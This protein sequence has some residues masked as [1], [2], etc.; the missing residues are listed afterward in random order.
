MLFV[1][2]WTWLCQLVFVDRRRPMFSLA[3]SVSH[4]TETGQYDVSTVTDASKTVRDKII[5]CDV[6][7]GERMVAATVLRWPNVLKQCP[8]E[9]MQWPSILKKCSSTPQTW[10]EVKSKCPPNTI[11]DGKA[12]HAEFR[13]LQNISTLVSN[14]RE[15]S[16][17]LL[18]FYVLASPC[19][20]RCTSETNDW[21][22]LQSIKSIKKWKNYAVVFTNIFV[23]RNGAQIPDEE[24]Q[25]AL[26]RLGNYVGLDNI[27]RCFK[28]KGKMQCINC[29]SSGAVARPCYSKE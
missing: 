25:G 21:S 4:N 1:K 2:F 20:K 22:I 7:V 16:N 15:G 13:T 26:E 12:D 29:S 14:H 6:Y 5:K 24:R 10:A 23:P 17:D 28:D 19:D 18:V 11:Q 8:D 9:R 27:F 3:V